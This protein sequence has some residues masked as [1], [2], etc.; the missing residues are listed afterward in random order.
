MRSE[1]VLKHHFILADVANVHHRT[2]VEHRCWQSKT[3]VVLDEGIEE[4]AGGSIICLT[5]LT[6]Q[7]GERAE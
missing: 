3:V 4:S 5:P 1:E 2:D 6:N 7:T